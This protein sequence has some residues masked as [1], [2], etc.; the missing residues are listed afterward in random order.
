M[1][2]AGWRVPLI[3]AWSVVC[4]C[5]G[6][7]SWDGVATVSRVGAA[8]LARAGL[9]GG[10]CPFPSARGTVPGLGGM[11]RGAARASARHGHLN[12][13]RAEKQLVACCRH[14]NTSVQV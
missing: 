13:R 10:Y 5:W 4:G 11:P 9:G 2:L 1:G 14:L 12:C 8:A 7:A 6:F 3:S